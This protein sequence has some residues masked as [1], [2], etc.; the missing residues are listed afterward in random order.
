MAFRKFSN[1][2][3]LYP[4]RHALFRF[5]KKLFST[6]KTKT[7]YKDGLVF[8]CDLQ[9]FWKPLK[10]HKN[11]NHKGYAAA[12]VKICYIF[13][14]LDISNDRNAPFLTVSYN[15]TK[16]QTGWFFSYWCITSEVISETLQRR[17]GK[18]QW[19][20]VRHKPGLWGLSQKYLDVGAG[21]WNVGPVPEMELVRKSSC[22]NIRMGFSF[23]WTELEP[24]PRTS[25][26][27]SWCWSQKFLMPTAGAGT[28]NLSSGSTA[29]T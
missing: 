29:L 22:T 4:R 18:E 11:S 1:E 14:K 6:L 8:F 2:S 26:C 28:W 13:D 17:H 27:W 10:F 15:Q 12:R 21:A 3:A 7:C 24:D 25:R 19:T 9:T 20:L 23:Q 16:W 5:A